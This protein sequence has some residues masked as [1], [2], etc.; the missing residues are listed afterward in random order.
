MDYEIAAAHPIIQKK[1]SDNCMSIRDQSTKWNSSFEMLDCALCYIE[2]AIIQTV[3][4]ESDL[5]NEVITA[6]EWQIL[7]YIRDFL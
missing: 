1:R 6:D 4:E 3:A 5:S 2:P 7:L